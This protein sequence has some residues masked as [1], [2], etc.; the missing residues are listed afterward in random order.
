MKVVLNQDVKGTGKKGQTVEVS[1]G[2]ARNFLLRKNLAIE[3]T[4]Q[5]INNAEAKAKAEKH[6]QEQLLQQAKEQ[7]AKLEGQQVTLK[8]KTG[9]TGKLFGAVTNKEIAD[10]L[11]KQFGYEL[12]KKK[13]VLAEPIKQAGSYQVEGDWS[14]ASYLL[15]AGA[16]GSRPVRV[17]G[18]RADSLQGDRA[19]LDILRAMGARAEVEGTSITVHPSALHGVDVDMGH[20]PDLVPTVAVLAAFAQGPTRVRNVAHLRIK[21]SDRI[22]APATELARLGVRV[23]EHD[24]GL[25]VHGTGP[26]G[27][28]WDE[29]ARFS[30]HN[31]HRIAMSLA[32]LGLPHGKRMDALLD[33]PLVVRKSFP[34]FWKVWERLL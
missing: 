27:P 12:D 18:L 28:V 15:A 26:D 7:A 6:R 22:T 25:T 4:Q 1:D 2:Y 9:E 33:D 23:D 5:N 13:I 17:D 16:L 24:D 34:T 8:V 19:M 10:V 20:C 32:L 3:A 29:A 14:G 11:Q 30:A 31:D 21:E